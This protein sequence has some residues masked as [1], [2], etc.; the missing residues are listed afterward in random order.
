VSVIS[1]N[2]TDEQMGIKE[3]AVAPRSLASS[4]ELDLKLFSISNIAEEIWARHENG[5]VFLHQDRIVLLTVSPMEVELAME[6]TLD[7]LKEV[8]QSIEKFLRLSVTIGV[9]TFVGEIGSLKSAYESALVALDYR[10]LYSLLEEQTCPRGGLS[11]SVPS[12]PHP[13][14]K[15]LIMQTNFSLTCRIWR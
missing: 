12:Y 7:A 11:A 4:H 10:R 1:V 3:G 9:G 2:H 15:S 13:C 8:L 6:R 5:K 14:C